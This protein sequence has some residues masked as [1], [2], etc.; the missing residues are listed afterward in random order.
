M[1][2]KYKES[3]MVLYNK[4]I[5]MGLTAIMIVLNKIKVTNDIS[6]KCII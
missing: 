6:N 4:Y 1:K 3:H 2:T 5:M